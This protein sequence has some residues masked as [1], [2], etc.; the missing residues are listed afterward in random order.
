MLKLK[1]MQQKNQAAAAAAATP[2]PVAGAEAAP[3]PAPA[4]G[5]APA[6]A[7]GAAQPENI[8]TVK[9]TGGGG[10]SKRRNAGQ[11][12][13]QKDLGELDKI[14]GTDLIFPDPDNVMQFN[15]IVTPQEGMYRT[16]RYEFDVKVPSSYPFDPP[17]VTCKTQI[18]HPNINWEGNVCLNI[19]REDWKPVLSISAVIFGIYTLFVEPNPSDPLNPEAA[20]HM[21]KNRQDFEQSVKATLRG[22]QHYGRQFP[23]LV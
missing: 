23:R 10:G 8:F 18:Y 2:P 19:L 14:P 1:Q 20:D 12:R 21:L 13:L 7:D 17:R 11:V 16:A 4:D 6:P 5:A 9:K 22:G 3:S 15:L